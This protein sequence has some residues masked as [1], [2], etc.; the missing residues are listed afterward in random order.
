[1]EGYK[2]AKYLEID[3]QEGPRQIEATHF[4]KDHTEGVAIRL[5]GGRPSE[6]KRLGSN[7]SGLIQR[8]VP[9]DGTAMFERRIVLRSVMFVRP[10]SPRRAVPVWS[11]RML[12]YK[13]CQRCKETVM[14]V[15]AHPF[16]VSMCD[17][18]LAEVCYTRC[19]F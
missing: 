11:M 3:E 2:A 13:D 8:V 15:V 12:A 9:H 6:L 17:S 1:V 14:N 16:Q 4:A 5:T 19:Y 7:N 18:E 10:K